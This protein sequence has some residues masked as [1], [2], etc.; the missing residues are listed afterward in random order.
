MKLSHLNNDLLF[1]KALNFL[2]IK[3]NIESTI[4]DLLVDAKKINPELVKTIADS[5][6]KLVKNVNNE[7]TKAEN[8]M[9]DKNILE[10]F[11][12]R[13][14][15]IQERIWA[16]IKRLDGNEFMPDAA[17][18]L[19]KILNEKNNILAELKTKIASV[20]IS[21]K[22]KPKIKRGTAQNIESRKKFINKD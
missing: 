22:D 10:N 12:S 16:A 18:E 9:T 13:L 14:D 11:K 8:I 15:N 7:F 6:D 21:A 3:A 2:S 20:L 4:N 19:K 17:E 5:V 1:E